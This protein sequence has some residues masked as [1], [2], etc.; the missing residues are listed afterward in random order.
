[1]EKDRYKP[2]IIQLDDEYF[3]E[4]TTHNSYILKEVGVIKTG[5][6][7]GEPTYKDLA[8]GD[9]PHLVRRYVEE[10]MHDD[11]AGKEIT[12]KEY[13]DKYEELTDDILNILE[14]IDDKYI[15]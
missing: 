4:S 10:T 15:T 9:V 14:E 3:I 5:V 11:L 6:N 7:K 8:H 1:M 12:L 2:H 13:V